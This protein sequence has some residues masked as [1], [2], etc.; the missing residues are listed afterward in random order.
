MAG[1]KPIGGLGLKPIFTGTGTRHEFLAR[2]AQALASA[3]EAA[4]L[5]ILLYEANDKEASATMKFLESGLGKPVYHRSECE[6]E[7]QLLILR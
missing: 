3:D 7:Y 5:F 4:G 1:Y 2:V 6:G